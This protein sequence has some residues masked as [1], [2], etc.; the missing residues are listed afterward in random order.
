MD[1]VKIL[2][3]SYKYKD[4]SHY[5]KNIENFFL[6]FIVQVQKWRD[7]LSLKPGGCWAVGML[8]YN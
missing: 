7:F 8:G 3:L 5:R 4:A 1:M 2:Y 6:N